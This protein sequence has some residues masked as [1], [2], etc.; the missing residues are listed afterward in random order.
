MTAL[1]SFGRSPL[2]GFIQ[3]PLKARGV[4]KKINYGLVGIWIMKPFSFDFITP[5]EQYVVF[6][7]FDFPFGGTPN[8]PGLPAPF[9]PPFQSTATSGSG[10]GGY[11]INKFTL[12]NSSVVV[13]TGLCNAI[14]SGQFVLHNGVYVEA[15]M[16]A[17][18]GAPIAGDASYGDVRPVTPPN[19]PFDF[20]IGVY[21]AYFP[22][23][24]TTQEQLFDA[25]SVFAPTIGF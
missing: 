8:P 21:G 22:I 12:N 20:S 24:Q 16:T 7:A 2:G 10:P 5:L 6:R 17:S 18:P 14:I 3:T 25:V 15:D 11:G 9:P 13:Y 23:L 19:L 4:G 1:N